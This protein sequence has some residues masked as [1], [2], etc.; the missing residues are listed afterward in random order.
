VNEL[1]TIKKRRTDREPQCGDEYQLPSHH[2]QEHARDFWSDGSRYPEEDFRQKAGGYKHASTLK[3]EQKSGSS[4]CQLAWNVHSKQQKIASVTDIH[5]QMLS[6]SD[7]IEP[8]SAAGW[9][10]ERACTW[11]NERLAVE[12]NVKSREHWVPLKNGKDRLT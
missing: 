12:G 5:Q 8:S 4:Q 10:E 1:P 6:E 2:G 9:H 3:Y 11:Q 7:L